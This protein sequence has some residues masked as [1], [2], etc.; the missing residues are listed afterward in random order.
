MLLGLHCL[1]RLCE[2]RTASRVGKSPL[3]SEQ[4][5]NITEDNIIYFLLE[6][7]GGAESTGR[8]VSF[9]LNEEDNVTVLQGVKV[10]A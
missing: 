1:I 8:K 5:G 7:M 2:W 4:A 6:D 9:G 10:N 3:L